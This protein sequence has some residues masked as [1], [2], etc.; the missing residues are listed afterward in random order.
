MEV[1]RRFYWVAKT[2]AGDEVRFFADSLRV[3]PTGAL[4]GT[5]TRS[6]GSEETVFTLAAVSAE[7]M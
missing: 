1:R 5:L 4:V 3:L 7:E 6:D 2:L